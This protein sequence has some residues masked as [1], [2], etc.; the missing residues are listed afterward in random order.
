MPN[1]DLNSPVSNITICIHQP[2]FVPYLGFFQ[3]LLI[4]QHFILL[5][6]VQ[7]IRR[8]WQHRDR[9]KGR[10]GPIWLTL[11]LR[12]GD[13]HQLINEVELSS[14]PSWIVANLNLLR[15]CYGKAKY[16]AE[17]F[18]RVE[19]I[20]YTGH[21]RLI[22]FNCAL[23]GL[24]MEYFD[25]S[26]SISLA[27]EYGVDTKSSARLLDLVRCRQGDTYLTGTGSRDY[28]DEEMF[29]EA[30]VRVMWQD[31]RHPVYPQLYGD[32]E[33]MLSC[34]D[35]LFNCGHDAASVLR[36]TLSD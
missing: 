3:R 6:D 15:E 30:G 13:Y 32:F 12:K 19:A 25:I 14:D 26:V 21:R 10:N 18:P 23:L 20:Y 4:S 1:V 27:S 2:D 17:V 16:F 8:G 34:L 35:L 29:K 5:D 31:F 24:A 28:L 7:F 33:P 9:I 11:A 36:S 22:D